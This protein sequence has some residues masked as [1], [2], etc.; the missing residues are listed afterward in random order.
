VVT[1]G[2]T[3]ARWGVVLL[4]LAAAGVLALLFGDPASATP[5][6]ALHGS[7]IVRKAGTGT[8]TV[9]GRPPVGDNIETGINCGVQCST[10]VTDTTDPTYVPMTLT[11]IPDPGSTFKGWTGDC[12]GTE[13]TCTM[14]PIGR[15]VNYYV[16]A[17]FDL[18]PAEAYP[19]AVTTVGNGRVTSAPAGID[20]G[21]TCAASFR[22]GSTVT[23]TAVAAPGW[24]FAGWGAACA[25]TGPCA[26]PVDGPK[27]VEATFTPPSQRLT[28]AVA[29]NGAV[30]SQPPGI[31]CGAACSA[32]LPSGTNVT[33]AAAPAPGSALRSWGGACTGGAPTCALALSAARAVTAVF[34]GATGQPLA[35]ST[36][37][38]GRVTSDRGGIACGE[39]CAAVVAG[40][41]VT[42][43]ARPS[44]GARFT[45]WSG[46]C[47]GN[48]ATCTLAMS[49]ARAAV[50][51]F[52]DAPRTYPL[53]VTT[54]GSGLVTSSPG[55]IR[56]RPACTA[57]MRAGSRVTLLAEPARRWAFVRWAG[58]CTGTRPSCTVTMTTAR[59]AT[60]TFA[61]NADQRAPRVT[62]LPS[63]GTGGTIVRLRYRV[64]DDS[65]RSRE[66]ATV[67]RGATRL[68]VV[69][70]RLDEAD[71]DALFYFLPWRA[72]REIGPGTL[73]FC[74]QAQDP[75]GNTSRRSCA[76][77]RLS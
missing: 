14:G 52:A 45:G 70:G 35:V 33:L 16:T 32:L 55:G 5:D 66:W 49:A 18:T 62:A 12:V 1:T 69:K 63:S 72:P 48:A 25:G 51:A 59:T 10:S 6:R 4:A 8:G 13:L 19:V 44:S 21:S 2:A 29:G 37:G 73:R 26:I 24:S 43:T 41:T 64:T 39:R 77:L 17:T 58:S 60:A 61:R 74:V 28:V 38:P 71:P 22:T 27:S 54:T 3:F 67:Y 20:C 75:T 7:L 68:A 76:R 11:A 40:G 31:S 15:L 46:A 42:L 56:C 23:L 36:S 50:A 47:T 53:A 57:S 65:G 9:K 34:D 30:A